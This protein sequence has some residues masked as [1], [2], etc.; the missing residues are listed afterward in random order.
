VAGFDQVQEPPSTTVSRGPSPQPRRHT[1]SAEHDSEHEP[2][3]VMSQ[4]A[5]SLQL[6]LL[7]GPTVI[8]QVDPPEQSRLHE[9]PHE[10]LHSLS[11]T[12]SSVQLSP[13]HAEPPMSHAAPGSQVHDIPTHVGGGVSFP[14]Q[15]T[16]SRNRPVQR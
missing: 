16:R 4:V 11:S 2:V 6:T 1:E 14:P 3:Q 12:Q 9:S 15:A 13:S 5:P 7:L 10:P 8:T